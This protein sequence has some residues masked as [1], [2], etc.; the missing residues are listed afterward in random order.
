MWRQ[1]DS[2]YFYALLGLTGIGV[3]SI[4]AG[5]IIVGIACGI[6]ALV[7]IWVWGRK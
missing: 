2:G 1:F 4:L 5:Y 6:I 3:V 7:I